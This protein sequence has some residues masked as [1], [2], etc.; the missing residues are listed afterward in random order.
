MAKVFFN[1]KT[2]QQIKKLELTQRKKNLQENINQNYQDTSDNWKMCALRERIKNEGKKSKNI[3]ELTLEA[4]LLR[5]DFSVTI[6]NS[7]NDVAIEII[8]KLSTVWR[9]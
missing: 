4:R 3:A 5:H 2:E 6:K 9:N 8:G 1:Q 7:N